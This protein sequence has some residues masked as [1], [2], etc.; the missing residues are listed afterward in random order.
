MTRG[1]RGWEREEG[2]GRG[3]GL[4]RGDEGLWKGETGY[5][6]TG[7]EGEGRGGGGRGE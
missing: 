6:A 7:K 5:M 4:L 1:G 3:E 2:G